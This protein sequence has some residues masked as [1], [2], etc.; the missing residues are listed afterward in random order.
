MPKAS[1]PPPAA[2][3]PIVDSATLFGRCLATIRADL[4]LTQ[5]AMAAL[6]RVSR[7]TLTHFETGRATPSFHVLL[8]LGQRVADARV[9]SDA[10][11]VLALMHLSARALQ[12]AGIRVLNRPVREGDV[13]LDF[14]KIDRVIGR[15]YDA[16]FREYV[17][18]KLADFAADDD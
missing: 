9:D 15:V 11:A 8:R 16:E 7:P 13:I 10:T 4:G 12:A 1:S 6:L 2:S 18:A 3:R 5:A 17:P 14:A